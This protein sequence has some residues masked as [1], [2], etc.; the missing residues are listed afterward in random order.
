[1]ACFG[2]H[3]MRRDMS[4]RQLGGRLRLSDRLGGR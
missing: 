1:L 4:G 2:R 3:D